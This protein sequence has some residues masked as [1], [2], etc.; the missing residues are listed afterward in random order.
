MVFISGSGIIETTDSGFS[1]LFLYFVQCG[2]FFLGGGG[3]NVRAWWSW[4]KFWAMGGFSGG[5]WWGK[6]RFA[7]AGIFLFVILVRRVFEEVRKI[8]DCEEVVVVD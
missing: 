4:E 3:W 6:W 2:F 8:G 5:F 7:M 1:F